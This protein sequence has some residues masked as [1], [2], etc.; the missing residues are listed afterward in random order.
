MKKEQFLE[1]TCLPSYQVS[2]HKCRSLLGDQIAQKINNSKLGHVYKYSITIL[3]QSHRTATQ[4]MSCCLPDI[5][6]KR[7][8]NIT[9]DI[10]AF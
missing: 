8:F 7:T 9:L 10:P 1:E 2:L 4:N 5:S 3:G 6:T